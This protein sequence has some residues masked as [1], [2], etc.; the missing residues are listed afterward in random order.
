MVPILSLWLPILLSAVIVFVVSSLLHMVLPYHRTDFTKLPA[1]DD[2]R[3]AFKN[4]D[5]PPGDYMMPWATTPEE[6]KSKEYATK[7]EEGPVAFLT[8]LGPN[9][10]G[11]GKNM[12]MW[13]VFCLVVSVIAA[14]VTGRA[15]DPGAHYLEVFRFAGCTA[16]T[17]YVLAL[18]QGSIWYK[19]AWSTTIKFSVDGLIYALLTA[20]TFGWLWPAA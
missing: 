15:A 10:I 3:A 8:V 1:E 9:Q 17:G 2:L 20:G 11:V 6:M 13:F 16:F 12:V 4:A 14:Y 18:W 19:R 7:L 5:I